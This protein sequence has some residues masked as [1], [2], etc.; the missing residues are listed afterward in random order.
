MTSTCLLGNLFSAPVYNKLLISCHKSVMTTLQ[1][2][3]YRT[4]SHILNWD[5]NLEHRW[6]VIG[7]AYS[8]FPT[9]SLQQPD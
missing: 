9:V 8:P 2:F 7:T 6:N 1:N 4:N 3:S 5:E